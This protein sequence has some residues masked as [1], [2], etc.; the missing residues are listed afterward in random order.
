MLYAKIVIT[1]SLL[2]AT[3]ECRNFNV[4]TKYRKQLKT[5]CKRLTNTVKNSPT[6]CRRNGVLLLIACFFLL[7]SSRAIKAR[8]LLENPKTH[9]DGKKCYRIEF[10]QPRPVPRRRAAKAAVQQ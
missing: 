4:T 3:T 8:H 5:T 10:R 7:F 2:Y 1:L 6:A 9:S